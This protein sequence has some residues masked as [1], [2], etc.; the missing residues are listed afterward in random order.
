[1]P[2]ATASPVILLSQQCNADVLP[3]RGAGITEASRLRAARCWSYALRLQLGEPV[4]DFSLVLSQASVPGAKDQA[5]VLMAI[6]AQLSETED[7]WRLQLRRKAGSCRMQDLDWL[8]VHAQAQQVEV[9]RVDPSPDMRCLQFAKPP[10]PAVFE[11]RLHALDALRVPALL[12]RFGATLSNL[13]HRFA[14]PARVALER[15]EDFR[16]DRLIDAQGRVQSMA[17]HLHDMLQAVLVDVDACTLTIECGYEFASTVAAMS[18]LPVLLSQ[19]Q[20]YSPKRSKAICKRVAMS[21]LR[22]HL[23]QRPVAGEFIIDL[24]IDIDPVPGKDFALRLRQLR[25]PVAAISDLW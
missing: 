6:E 22:W 5:P 21:L 8:P 10:Q 24:G 11:V 19:P 12:A 14:E 13:P 20:A 25:L 15:H 7:M 3:A 16:I 17:A 9:P 2:T 4:A 18:R 23:D 1:M